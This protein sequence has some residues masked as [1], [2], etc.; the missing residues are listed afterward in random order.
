MYFML[1]SMN[2]ARNEMN[3]SHRKMNPKPEIT[4]PAQTMIF[5]GTY[6]Y[7]MVRDSCHILADSLRKTNCWRSWNESETSKN[8]SW[9]KQG[10][11]TWRIHNYMCGIILWPCGFISE[12][13]GLI[14]KFRGLMENTWIHALVIWILAEKCYLPWLWRCLKRVTYPFFGKKLRIHDKCSGFC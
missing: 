14:E 9:R 12:Y 2:P 1:D 13:F 6:S 5:F 8:E 7:I 11:F 3:P 4:N 10:T